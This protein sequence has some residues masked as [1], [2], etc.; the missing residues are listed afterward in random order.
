[1]DRSLVYVTL[2]YTSLDQEPEL[3]FLQLKLC[4]PVICGTVPYSIKH[5]LAVIYS[6][7]VHRRRSGMSAGVV[8]L[9]DTLVHVFSYLC[10]EVTRVVEIK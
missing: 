10:S 1:M 5:K 3:S 8:L 7:Q 2:G 4:T 6:L 9:N